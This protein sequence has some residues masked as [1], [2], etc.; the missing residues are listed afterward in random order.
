MV[1]PWLERSDLDSPS[2]PFAEYA[3]NSATWI[4][5]GLSGRKY[6]GVSEITEQYVC[7]DY[8]LPLG[9]APLDKTRFQ[10]A[11]GFYGYFV[12]PQ[13]YGTQ[14][15]YGIRFK[16]RQQPVRKISAV[17]IGEVLLPS[18]SY[19]IRNSSEL[20]ISGN[21]CSSLCDGPLVTYKYGV[22]PPDSGKLAAIDLANELIKAYNGADCDLPDNVTSVTRQGVS[23]EIFDPNMFLESGQL[24]LRSADL[25]L[26]VSNPGKAKKPAKVFSPDDPI[27]Y[28]RR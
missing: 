26:A 10:N 1:Q 28:T 13:L 25:F 11:A 3:I 24:G 19:Y 20:V 5:W 15:G 12:P 18:S 14:A 2:D 27:G 8:D 23:F 22:H 21:Y 16:L 7:R 6:N 4:L 9:C 17:H